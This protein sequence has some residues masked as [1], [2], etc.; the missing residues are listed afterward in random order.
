MLRSLREKIKH[1]TKI[2][3]DFLKNKVFTKNKLTGSKQKKQ[4]SELREL[5]NASVSTSK[6]NRKL[7]P[8]SIHFPETLPVSLRAKEIRD[9]LREN[10]VNS[11]WRYRFWQNYA[12]TENMPRC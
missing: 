4:I 11:C 3:I 9:S 2:F 5:I 10:G 8:K 12:V 1:S 6:S 7:I